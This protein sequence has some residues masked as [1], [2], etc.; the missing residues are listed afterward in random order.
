LTWLPSKLPKYCKIVISCVY[1]PEDDEI[2]ADYLL[3]RR[4]LDDE[5][6]FL[7]VSSL[8]ENLATAVIRRWLVANN[9]DVNNY[10]WRV[11]CN[12]LAECSLPIFVKLVSR[13]VL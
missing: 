3:L 9:R 8:G 6:V 13:F 11:V 7:E 4:I 12:A 1:E 5:K 10:Q 2:S